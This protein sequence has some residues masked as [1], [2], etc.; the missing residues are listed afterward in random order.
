MQAAAD[1]IAK[2][3]SALIR[4]EH[5]TNNNPTRG[6]AAGVA[7]IL[8]KIRVADFYSEG[9]RFESCRDRHYPSGTLINRAFLELLVTDVGSVSHSI[10]LAV[11]C[12][13]TVNDD[14]VVAARARASVL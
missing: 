8:N 4:P 10:V 11:F 13:R 1:S 6:S 12:R 14:G 9:C 2:P 5:L 3:R 7:G